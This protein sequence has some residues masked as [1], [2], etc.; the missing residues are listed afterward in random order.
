MP[1][2]IYVDGMKNKFNGS[3][4]ALQAQLKSV[5]GMGSWNRVA[6]GWMVRNTNGANFHWNEN[7]KTWWL[8]GGFSAQI[9]L[10]S[11]IQAILNKNVVFFSFQVI[12]SGVPS[13]EAQI[14]AYLVGLGLQVK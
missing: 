10:K 5:T 2:R 4:A 1:R 14:R 8:S 7:T 3:L 13:F 11:Q 9:A 6:N 12:G